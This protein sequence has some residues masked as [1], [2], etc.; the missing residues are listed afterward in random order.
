MKH[1]KTV[2]RYLAN[3]IEEDEEDEK[4]EIFSWALGAEWMSHFPKFLLARDKL[5][6]RMNFRAVV[7]RRTCEEVKPYFLLTLVGVFCSIPSMIA[8]HVCCLV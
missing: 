3:D 2:Y 5:W 7:S 1:L 6:N 4:Y 8:C